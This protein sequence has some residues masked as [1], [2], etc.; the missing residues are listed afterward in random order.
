MI[1]TQAMIINLKSK[2]IERIL[3]ISEFIDDKIRY[4]KITRILSGSSQ[5]KPQYILCQYYY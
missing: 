2:V 1:S 3:D 5:D 4:F